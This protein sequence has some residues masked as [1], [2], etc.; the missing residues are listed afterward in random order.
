MQMAMVSHAIV[1]R[2]RSN[3]HACMHAIAH[4][5]ALTVLSLRGSLAISSS[6]LCSLLS[7]RRVIQCARIT[8]IARLFLCVFRKR[9]SS[10][11]LYAPFT[12]DSAAT[13]ARGKK[14]PLPLRHTVRTLHP[15]NNNTSGVDVV[16]ARIQIKKLATVQRNETAPNRTRCS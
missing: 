3:M 1:A 2:P 5:Q 13:Y 10:A 9:N 7:V 16:H 4:I 8:P 12:K 15:Q 14:A 6:I 11:F